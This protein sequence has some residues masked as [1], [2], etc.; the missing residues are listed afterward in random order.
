LINNKHYFSRGLQ[1]QYVWNEVKNSHNVK[2]KAEQIKKSGK[3]LEVRKKYVDLKNLY[4]SRQDKDHPS[5]IVYI[6]AVNQVYN[7]YY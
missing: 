5:F 2:E 1:G 3:W 7:K 4:L 6:E